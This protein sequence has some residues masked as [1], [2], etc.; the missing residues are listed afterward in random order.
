MSSLSGMDILLFDL[1][2][3]LPAV[4]LL[5]LTKSTSGA[6][7]NFHHS[8]PGPLGLG[9]LAHMSHINSFSSLSSL[10]M[11]SSSES[12]FATLTTNMP[13]TSPSFAGSR[14][15]SSGQLLP[16]PAHAE[17]LCMSG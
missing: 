16:V 4:N 17:R 5:S 6:S 10:T 8:R 14:R 3:R 11:H 2:G 15:L 7:R 12:P 9:S 1:P 13:A